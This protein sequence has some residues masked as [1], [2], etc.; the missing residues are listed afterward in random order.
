MTQT[1][2]FKGRVLVPYAYGRFGWTR[3]GGKTYYATCVE[4]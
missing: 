1:G 2:I 4:D 3:G